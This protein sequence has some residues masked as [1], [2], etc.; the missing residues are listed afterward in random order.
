MRRQGRLHQCRVIELAG[1]PV[2]IGEEQHGAEATVIPRR[3]VVDGGGQHVVQ[4]RGPRRD[5]G[6]GFNG[7]G[8]LVRPCGVAQQ[9]DGGLAGL[10]GSDNRDAIQPGR[11]HKLPGEA[12]H[13]GR[14]LVAPAEAALVI[15]LEVV[16]VGV[17]HQ[18]HVHPHRHA[19]GEGVGDGHAVLAQHQARQVG[20]GGA[21]R[22]GGQYAHG[23]AGEGRG[24]DG[25]DA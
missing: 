17:E 16:G 19:R 22:A 24:I 3:Q 15:E 4:W 13:T 12:A 14:H 5:R 10:I 23:H 2:P 18:R 1:Q 8:D 25:R 9:E 21:A 7:R 11:I 20:H 6:V